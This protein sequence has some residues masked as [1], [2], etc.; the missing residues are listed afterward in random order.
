[1]RLHLH[2]ETPGGPEQGDEEVPEGNLLQGAFE[3]GFAQ[4]ANYGLELAHIGAGR[5]PTRLDVQFGDPQVVLVEEG[6]KVFCQVGLVFV[7]QASDH[8]AVDRDVARV[9][10][11]G[12]V[13]EYVPGMHVRMEEVVFE[14][15]REERLDPARRKFLHVGPAGFQFRDIGDRH[16]LHPLDHEHVFMTV[17]PIDS[18]RV[19]QRRIGEVASQRRR[20]GGFE[21]QVQL[22]EDVSLV[23][24]DHRLEPQPAG[25]A[26]EA[27]KQRRDPVQQRE[28]LLDEGFDVGPQ[29]LDH[30]LDATG[31][32]CT[33]HL[34]Q[35]GGGE[36]LFIERG[37]NLSDGFAGARLD[38]RDRGLCRKGRHAVLEL[39]EFVGEIRRQQ[40][41][42]GGEDLAELD[43]DRAEILDCEP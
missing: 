34:R 9:L 30:H 7:R 17:L 29:D 6:E 40:V 21:Q 36:G 25:I 31:Q 2:V 5:N 42:P 14:D 18:R 15:L 43:E 41:A 24:G 27:L 38:T 4:L 22:V 26:G 33:V 39:R 32:R 13:D 19:Q 10:R 35:G 1:M 37:E 3:D 23:V 20:I 12:D 8:C 16:A 11:V 28:V